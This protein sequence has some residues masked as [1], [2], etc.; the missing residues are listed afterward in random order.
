M[1]KLVTA[2]MKSSGGEGVIILSQAGSTR[3]AL[4]EE[5]ALMDVASPP[6]ADEMRLQQNLEL[7]CDIARA[8][9]D[10]E[11]VAPEGRVHISASDL[12]DW[13]TGPGYLH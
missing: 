7:F 6:R 12:N 2:F 13:K 5:Q 9:F 10:L 4:V 11:K 1:F 8:K 3:I